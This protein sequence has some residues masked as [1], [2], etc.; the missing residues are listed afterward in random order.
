MNVSTTTDASVDLK[1]ELLLLPFT[2]APPDPFAEALSGALGTVVERAIQD[3]E[4]GEGKARVLY[5]ERTEALRIA[6]LRLGASSDLDADVLRRGRAIEA[7][8]VRDCEADTVACLM[9]V[10]DEPGDLRI[11]QALVEGFALGSY[12]YRR[13]KTADGSDGPSAF[14]VCVRKGH[15]QDALENGAVPGGRLADAVGAARDLV[16][17]SPD[18]KAARQFGDAVT[19]SGDT[20]GYDVETWGEDRIREEGVGRLLVVNRGSVELPTFSVLTWAPEEAVNERSLVLAGKG[21]VLDTGGL[22]LKDTKGS[23]GMMKAGLWRAAAVV[24]AF[25]ALAPLRC[26]SGSWGCCLPPTI[27]R[28]GARACRGMSCAC[29]P[30]RPSKS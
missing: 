26:R 8:V 9:P 27:A 7:D 16:H 25:E 4:A 29:I 28:L 10:E 17:R 24:G 14:F 6:F 23:M 12:Q 1:V 11:A 13:Y 5:P 18:G 22:S 30:A 21:G 19:A 2:E 20:H 15:D 3:F